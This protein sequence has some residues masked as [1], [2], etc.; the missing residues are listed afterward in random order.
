MSTAKVIR[1][2]QR[3]TQVERKA[4]KKASALVEERREENRKGKK[5]KMKEI[6]RGETSAEMREEKK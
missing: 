6:W 2:G 5:Y 3:E 1:K 4:R